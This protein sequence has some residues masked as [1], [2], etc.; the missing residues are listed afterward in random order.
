MMWTQLDLRRSSARFAQNRS[1]RLRVVESKT[2]LRFIA[3]GAVTIESVGGSILL[4]T[5][6]WLR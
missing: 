5:T 2:V 4:I 3:R 1:H 6:A